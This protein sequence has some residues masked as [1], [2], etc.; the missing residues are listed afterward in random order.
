MHYF[1]IFSPICSIKTE[2]FIDQ[3]QYYFNDNIENG[4][5]RKTLRIFV[6]STFKDMHG[7]RNL[8][9]RYIFPELIRRAKNLLNID[10]FPIGKNHAL[11]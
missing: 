10:V 6:S 5:T 1:S 9:T 3:Q 2:K 4:L 8:M 11:K 7:E